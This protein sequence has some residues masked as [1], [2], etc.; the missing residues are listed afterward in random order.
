GQELAR[1]NAPSGLV[2][3]S[4]G[5]EMCGGDPASE[6]SA[7][8]RSLKIDFGVQVVGFG[9]KPDERQALEEIARAGKGKYYD[10]PTPVALRDVVQRLAK[11]VVERA[12]PAPVGQTVARRSRGQG[13]HVTV[14]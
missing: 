13:R 9:V 14:Q 12:K 11:Q 6:A 4:D 3:I 8:A 7:L 2:L 1:V 5:K 10:A